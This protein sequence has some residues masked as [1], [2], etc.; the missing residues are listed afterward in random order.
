[1]NKYVC[2]PDRYGQRH[3]GSAFKYTNSFLL[4]SHFDPFNGPLGVFPGIKPFIPL[5]KPGQQTL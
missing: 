5:N 4:L 1:M 3:L 2:I